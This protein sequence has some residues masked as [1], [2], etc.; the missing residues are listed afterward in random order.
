MLSNLF[1]LHGLG[2]HTTL[3]I[4]SETRL[5]NLMETTECSHGKYKKMLF[6]M[7]VIIEHKYHSVYVQMHAEYI[8]MQHKAI[9]PGFLLPTIF[10]GEK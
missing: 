6:L 1:F 7:K 4:S 3:N 2:S 8:M 10:M 5:A 9:C